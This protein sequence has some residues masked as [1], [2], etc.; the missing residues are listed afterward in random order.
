MASFG[1][2]FDIDGFRAVM[3]RKGIAR[4]NLY[5]VQITPP[6]GLNTKAM[7]MPKSA[8]DVY[9]EFFLE[10]TLLTFCFIQLK[11]VSW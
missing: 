2:G 6:P 3:Q 11:K 8:G 7:N 1:R 5:K 4:N 10:K 9:Q